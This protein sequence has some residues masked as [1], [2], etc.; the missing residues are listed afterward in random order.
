[1]QSESIVNLAKSLI[2]FQGEVDPI[3]KN[4]HSHHGNYSDL[5]ITVKTARPFLTKHNLAVSQPPMYN[6]DNGLLKGGVRTLLIHSSGEWID[7]ETVLPLKGSNIA[8]ALGSNI[9]YLRRYG[10]SSI[11]GLVSEDDNDGNTPMKDE[12]P[13]NQQPNHK[14]MPPSP[15]DAKKVK[16]ETIAIMRRLGCKETA[17]IEA[18]IAGMVATGLTGQGVLTD[19]RNREANKEIWSNVTKM[20]VAA[21]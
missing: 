1:M 9:S 12:P 18:W 14:T 4:A 17:T 2:A 11:L 16:N 3:I 15:V 6:E 20:F 10:F 8:Q 5:K 7:G 19:I 13:R 21:N